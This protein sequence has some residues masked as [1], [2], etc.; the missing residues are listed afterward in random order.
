MPQW[1]PPL[2][3]GATSTGARTTVADSD[4]PQWS[5]P[6]GGGATAREIRAL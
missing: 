2:G 4:A 1:S 3:G 5:P 6:L